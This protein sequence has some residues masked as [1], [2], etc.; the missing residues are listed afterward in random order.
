MPKEFYFVPTPT[1]GS[2]TFETYYQHLHLHQTH[3]AQLRSFTICT[4][5]T[6]FDPDGTHPRIMAFETALLS[7][8]SPTSNQALFSSVEPIQTSQI[9]GR[10]LIITSTDLLHDAETFINAA[11]QSLNAH[12]KNH[13]KL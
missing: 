7:Q 8:Q 5:I 11:L 12:P 3:I 9:D 13:A 10:Y 4:D 6:V 2:M 1:N